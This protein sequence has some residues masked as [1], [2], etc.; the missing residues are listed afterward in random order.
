MRLVDCEIDLRVGGSLSFAYETTSGRKIGVKGVFERVDVPRGFTYLESYDF[1]PLTQQVTIDLS[2][3]RSSTQF[4]QTLRYRTQQERDTDF[5]NIA[6]SS[7]AAYANLEQY[8]GNAHTSE[9][10]Q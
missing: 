8:L 2:G 1:S 10:K 7:P 9:K 3:T 5:D 6:S 4:K